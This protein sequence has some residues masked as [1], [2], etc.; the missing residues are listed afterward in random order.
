MLVM[1]KI[2][3]VLLVLAVTTGVFAQGDWSIGAGAEVTSRINLDP[4]YN[5]DDT[6][7]YVAIAGGTGYHIY[8]W[9]GKTTGVVNIGYS[10]GNLSASVDLHHYD[11]LGSQVTVDGGNYKFQAATNL[12]NILHFNTGDPTATIDRLW[13]YYKL[14]NGMV[15]LEAAYNSRD[16]FNP[17]T[18]DVT[19]AF[20]GSAGRGEDFH[21]LFKDGGNYTGFDHHNYLLTNITVANLE[22]GLVLPSLFVNRE[23]RADNQRVNINGDNVTGENIL[24]YPG[25]DPATV[26]KG[27]W[28]DESA[29]YVRLVDHVL[30]KMV[31]GVKFGME[32]IEFAAQL[33]VDDYAVYLGAKFFS[34][35]VTVGF[36]F[37]GVLASDTETHMKAGLSLGYNAGSFGAGVRAKLDNWSDKDSSKAESTISFEPNFY[38]MAMPTHLQFNLAT[39]FY[40][41]SGT[42]IIGEKIPMDTYWGIQPQLIWNFMGTGSGWG[43]TSGAYDGYYMID[44]G[45]IFRYRMYSGKITTNAL[46][47]CFKFRS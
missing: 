19:G 26:G 8:D 11:R 33:L 23:A 21:D 18:S 5:K 1:K 20:G 2:L 45:M 32:P 34:G 10:L 42:D 36:S 40:F 9:Y 12:V 44:T 4:N 3:V 29:A 7:D 41:A 25:Q 17:W 30:K 39:G 38:Y 31:F 35:P 6:G 43:S 47:I 27:Y 24:N 46:D 22:F 13:G 15:H 28:A 37:N 14:I 16:A